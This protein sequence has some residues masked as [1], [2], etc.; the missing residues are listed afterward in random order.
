MSAKDSLRTVAQYI[1]DRL[2]CI[3]DPYRNRGISD[4]RHK[5]PGLKKLVRV[6]KC[7]SWVVLGFVSQSGAQCVHL[8]K[9]NR[10]RCMMYSLQLHSQSHVQVVL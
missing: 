7:R 8:Q 5:L 10:V 1:S 6:R 4:W 9:H 2:Y 3:P